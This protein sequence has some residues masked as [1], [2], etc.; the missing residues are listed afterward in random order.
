MSAEAIA[1]ILVFAA[2]GVLAGFTWWMGKV[3]SDQL[4]D[5]RKE[6]K[7]ARQPALVVKDIWVEEAPAGAGPAA[8]TFISKGIANLGAYSVAIHLV[9]VLDN[10]GKVLAESHPMTVIPA[11]QAIGAGKAPLFETVR[12]VGDDPLTYAEIAERA[13]WLVLRF[14]SG[15]ASTERWHF[16]LPRVPRKHYKPEIMAFKGEDSKATLTGPG[17]EFA[18]SERGHLH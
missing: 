7:E 17:S 8:F 18:S 6:M 16:P 14:R 13:S 5:R 10:D 3:S 11:G 12:A 2:T 9:E 4:K 1:G 15:T